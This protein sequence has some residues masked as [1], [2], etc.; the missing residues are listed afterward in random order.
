[1]LRMEIQVAPNLAVDMSSLEAFCEKW[2]ITAF[3]LFGSVLRDDF[4]QNSDIDV[5]VSFEPDKWPSLLQRTD[6]ER[7]LTEMFGRRTEMIIREALWGWRVPESLRDRILS[8]TKELYGH[9][10]ND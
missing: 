10:W 9:A 4:R 5:L 7:E 6:A 1:M 8:E 2:G 3:G